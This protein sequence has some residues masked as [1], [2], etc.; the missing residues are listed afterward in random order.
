MFPSMSPDQP[1]SR[2]A[3]LTDSAV[4]KRSSGGWARWLRI[5]LGFGIIALLLTQI[6]LQ[7]ALR[8]VVEA[9]VE[10]LVLGFAIVFGSRLLAGVRWYVLLR[11]RHAGV[12]LVGLLR[13]MFVADFV[14]YFMP[15][16]IG[17][18]V[19]RIYGL[20]KT[21]ADPALSATSVVVERLVALV[22]LVLLVL[23]GLAARP[24]ALPAEIGRLAWLFLALLLIA[25]LA[26][27]ARPTRRLA[28]GLLPGERLARIRRG[29][30]RVF[31]AL[32][33]YRS[34]PWLIAGSFLLALI[35]QLLRC[36]SVTVSAAALGHPLPFTFVLVVLPIMLLVSL[37]PITIAG[38]GVR[39]AGF[40]YFLGL[41]GMP[42]EVA[43]PLAL[44]QRVFT[45]VATLPGAWW[46]VR[47]GLHD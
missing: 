5:G 34:R 12:T 47:R 45:I 4:A 6:D 14:G 31:A 20:A 33:S 32:D 28:L 38:L 42:A 41:G 35:F 3:G 10:L 36:A 44:I 40:V 24:L 19:L 18:E 17:V 21:T 29:L 2:P 9:R 43:L 7:A 13:L 16:S 23:V 8:A 15:G 1:K 26:I 39:E 46:Y 30:E 11:G 27:M 37:L 22:V 25:V